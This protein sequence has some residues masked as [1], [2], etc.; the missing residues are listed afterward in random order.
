MTFISVYIQEGETALYV[1]SEKGYFEI[2]Q[3]L[4]KANASTDIANK[5]NIL[6]KVISIFP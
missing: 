6:I 3:I 1:A 4:L 5:V 2:V